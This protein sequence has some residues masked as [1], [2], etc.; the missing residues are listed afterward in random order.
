MTPSEHRH[1]QGRHQ[2]RRP[3]PPRPRSRARSAPSPTW[4]DERLGLAASAKKNLRKVFP[5]HWS[6][7]LGEIALWSFVVLLLTGVFLTLWFNPSMGEVD[8][9]RLLRPAARHPRCPRPTPRRCDIS[10]DVR[11]GLLMRQMH[12][13]AAMLFIAAMMVHMLRVFFTGAFRKPR[14]LNWVIGSPAAAARHAR[15]LHRLLAARRPALRHRH[16]R[17]GRLHEVDPGRRHLHVVLPLRRRVP[18]RRRSSPAST[19]STC[20]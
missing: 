4:A 12:H 1:E 6:F 18:G 10:F 9:Q 3:P 8:L 7:M 14:E 17:R 15:G 13:W 5:D 2:Q 20:C 16:P 11:G 19:P